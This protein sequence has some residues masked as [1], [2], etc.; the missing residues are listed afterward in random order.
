MLFEDETDRP[1]DQTSSKG[2]ASV[3]AMIQTFVIII[4]AYLTSYE[5]HSH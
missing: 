2:P 1:S 4:L 3:K 5:P